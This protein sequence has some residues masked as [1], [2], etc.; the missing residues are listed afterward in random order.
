MDIEVSEQPLDT[1]ARIEE[2]IE[3]DTVSDMAD[4]GDG[5]EGGRCVYEMEKRD[6]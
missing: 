4:E 2:R 3:L 1:R 6:G 5:V